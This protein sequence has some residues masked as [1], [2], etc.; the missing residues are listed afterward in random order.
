MRNS[1]SRASLTLVPRILMKFAAALF[2]TTV[3]FSMFYWFNNNLSLWQARIMWPQKPF[4]SEAFKAGSEQ[5]RAQMVV[6]LIS[7]QILLKTDHEKITNMLGEETGDYYVTDSNF[8]YRLT[9]RGSADW[10]LTLVPGNN[11]KIDQV[12]I[13]K[14]CCSISKQ[15]LRLALEALDPLISWLL[16]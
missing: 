13:R 2:A 4:S 5:D 16:K 12:F 7:S 1:S 15:A 3:S 14:S 6:D 8:T 11:G 9:N 10:I